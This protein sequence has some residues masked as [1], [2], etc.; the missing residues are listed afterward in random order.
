M[1]SHQFI[2][3]HEVS[4]KNGWCSNKIFELLKEVKTRVKSINLC[5]WKTSTYI[6]LEYL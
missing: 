6:V 4:H 1:Y 2:L 5:Y 3:N